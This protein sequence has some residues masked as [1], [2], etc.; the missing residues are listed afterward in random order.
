[1]C[2]YV[3]MNASMQNVC[4]YECMPACM[5]VYLFLY[6]NV[7]VYGYGYGSGYGDGSVSRY[8]CIHDYIY[9][10]IY[11]YIY[12]FLHLPGRSVHIAA[13]LTE[14][15]SGWNTCHNRHGVDATSS[16]PSSSPQGS[17][18]SRGGPVHNCAT[19][20]V[21]KKLQAQRSQATNPPFCSKGSDYLIP[22]QLKRNHA[23][24]FSQN[25][26]KPR[27]PKS[28]IPRRDP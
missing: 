19:I 28:F 27:N 16:S 6:V 4:R 25:N 9:T 26:T 11:I 22:K 10:Y 18:L 21:P 13:L 5:C 20:K 23:K 7:H 15:A 2:M 17:M 14:T 8:R 24:P 1:M 12:V 3:L